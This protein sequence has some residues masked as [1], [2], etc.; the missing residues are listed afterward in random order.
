MLLAHLLCVIGGFGSLAYNGL[1]VSL[2]R[3]RGSAG[4][5]A[6]DIN[7]QVSGLAELLIYGA[8]LFGIAAVATSQSTWKFSQAWVWLAFA[9]FILDVGILHGLIRRSQREYLALTARL[10]SL[11]AYQAGGDS[12]GGAPPPAEVARLTAMEKRVSLSWGLFNF[13]VVVV[14]YLMVFRP[15]A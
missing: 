10:A 7:R 6:L 4:A 1:Y 5:A 15:G 14:V 8:F 2:A 9:L 12:G 3:R 11:P 13:I